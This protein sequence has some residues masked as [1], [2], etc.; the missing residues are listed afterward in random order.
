MTSGARDVVVVGGG[1]W[2]PDTNFPIHQTI[3]ILAQKHRVLYVCRESHASLLGQVAGRLRGFHSFGELARQALRRPGVRQ[4]SERI[5]VC[6]VTG[7]AGALPLSYPPAARRLVAAVVIAQMRS[8]LHSLEFSEPLL[9]FYWWFFPEIARAIPHGLAVYDIYDDH[10]QYD[11]V[12]SNPTRQQYTRRIEREL[13]A[14]VDLAFAVS[15]KLEQIKSGGAP[16][17][18]LPNGVDLA[19][20]KRA[21]AC[22]IPAD[23]ACLPRPIVG[24]LGSY[25]SRLDWPLV[26]G[27]ARARPT[28]SFAFVGGGYTLPVD[29]PPN[30]HLIGNR[31]YPDAMCYVHWFDL[32]VIPFV[33]DELTAAIC[34][35][36]LFD[37]L[38]LGKPI[39]S[40]PLPAIDEVVGNGQEVYRFASVDQF[41]ALAETALKEDPAL[42]EARMA[43]AGRLTWETRVE[44]AMQWINELEDDRFAS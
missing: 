33:L 41:V 24:Y 26:T 16:V 25:D 15:R 40:T 17:R 27:I 3:R 13:L 31:A 28:W 2:S 11:F 38:A 34:P 21:R 42:S 43:R 36:K 5:W 9:W 23:L 12:R 44:Q 35:A 1:P 22:T 37:Y 7:L 20:A 14:E 32:A 39:L 30:L 19:V 6:A 4:V 18:Y 8:A 10:A 29:P